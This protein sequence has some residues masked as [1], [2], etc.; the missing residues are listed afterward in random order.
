MYTIDLQLSTW[1]YRGPWPVW[2]P[3]RIR[4]VQLY[5]NVPIK[6]I[7]NRLRA[8]EKDLQPILVYQI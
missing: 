7:F 2:G 3:V 6:T 5:M 1:R 4:L 8:H